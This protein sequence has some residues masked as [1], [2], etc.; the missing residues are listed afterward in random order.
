MVSCLENAIQRFNSLSRRGS[1]AILL[2][3][4]TPNMEYRLAGDLSRLLLLRAHVVLCI[5][6]NDLG[7]W[8]VYDFVNISS[9][10]EVGVSFANT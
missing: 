3:M 6:E 2:D 5:V 9:Y 8:L 7:A 10:C 1:I 4:T